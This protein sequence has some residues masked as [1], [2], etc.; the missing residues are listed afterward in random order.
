MTD[1]GL[2][3]TLLDAARAAWHAMWEGDG[4]RMWATDA[5]TFL[6]FDRIALLRDRAEIL[7]HWEKRRAEYRHVADRWALLAQWNCGALT[8]LVADVQF[9]LTALSRATVERR[10]ATLTIA[11]RGSD[12]QHSVVHLGEAVPAALVMM[13]S[14]YE[15]EARLA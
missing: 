12:P 15:R 5:A 9:D 4:A 8:L 6:P 13:L 10:N 14:G 7:E 1:A 3:D 11:C 2:Q